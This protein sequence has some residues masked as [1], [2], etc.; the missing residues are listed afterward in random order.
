[1]ILVA[2]NVE[3]EKSFNSSESSSFP[4]VYDTRLEV[5]QGGAEVAKAI[6]DPPEH[7]S[8][9]TL[10]S[11]MTPRIQNNKAVCKRMGA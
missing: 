8:K 6:R 5:F 9:K 3:Q 11:K 2:G 4:P 1:M 10:D 7:A